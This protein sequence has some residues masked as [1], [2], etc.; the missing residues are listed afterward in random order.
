MALSHQ[1][2][3]KKSHL[4]QY[5]HANSHHFPAQKLGVLNTLAT[6]DLR[7][8]HDKHLNEEKAHL[9]NVFINNGYSR[10]QCTKAFLRA[11]KCPNAK[12]YTKDRFSGVHLPFIQ[13]TTNK[14]VRILR[15]HKVDS[16]FRSLNTI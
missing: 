14:I 12:K 8:S 6:R 3:C 7:V 16:T 1:V 2:F 5:L 4:E 9:L 15:K 10:H 13:G 11:R